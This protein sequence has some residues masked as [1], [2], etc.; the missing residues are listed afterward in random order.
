MARL[1]RTEKTN[2]CWI[3]LIL[4]CFHK[5]SLDGIFGFSISSYDEFELV[6]DSVQLNKKTQ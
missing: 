4:L 6:Y 3:G 2:P 5:N 1:C